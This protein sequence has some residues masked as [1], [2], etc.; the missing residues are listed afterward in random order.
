MINQMGQIEVPEGF[1]L[2]DGDSSYIAV[3]PRDCSLCAF[4]RF[5][6]YTPCYCLACCASERS[7][8]IG[9]HFVKEGGTM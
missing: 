3:R 9:I 5:V 8:G 4:Y 1:I 7:D 2:S 6:G